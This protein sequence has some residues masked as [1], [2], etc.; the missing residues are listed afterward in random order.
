MSRKLNILAWTLLLI[1]CFYCYQIGHKQGRKSMHA[2]T[3]A[4]FEV[5]TGE[6]VAVGDTLVTKAGLVKVVKVKRPGEN[7]CMICHINGDY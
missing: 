3:V 6:A 1:A 5:R 4:F 7:L 2:D